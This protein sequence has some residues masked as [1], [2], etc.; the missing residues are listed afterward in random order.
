MI[1][2]VYNIKESWIFTHENKPSLQ[3]FN[4]I[5]SNSTT[6]T[7]TAAFIEHPNNFNIKIRM[8]DNDV[9]SYKWNLIK[10][11]DNVYYKVTDI[12]IHLNH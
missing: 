5:L 3:L 6:S 12:Q 7:V 4:T 2:T 10:L 11:N 8:S 9:F 1:I